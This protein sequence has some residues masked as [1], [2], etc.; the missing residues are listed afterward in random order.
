[1]TTMKRS[2]RRACLVL[3]LPLLLGACATPR[4]ESTPTERAPE[5]ID[6]WL[7]PDL[8]ARVEHALAAHGGGFLR[9]IHEALGGTASYEEIRIV[10]AWKDSSASRP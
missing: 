6:P 10:A 3:L 9:P 8:Q 5:R 1:M 7:D 2:L 4:L